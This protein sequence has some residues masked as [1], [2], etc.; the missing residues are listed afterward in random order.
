MPVCGYVFDNSCAFLLDK[1]LKDS[2][3]FVK[4]IA[5]AVESAPVAS[6]CSFD[7]VDFIVFVVRMTTKAGFV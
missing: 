6:S 4:A 5:K 3:C 7:V 1:G 2:F